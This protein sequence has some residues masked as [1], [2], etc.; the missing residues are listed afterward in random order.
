MAAPHRGY[1]IGERQLRVGMLGHVYYRKVVGNEGIGNAA[2]GERDEQALRLRR[3]PCDR[4]PRVISACR[5]D[6]RQ[7]ALHQCDAKRENQGELSKLGNHYF[8]FGGTTSDCA[9]V[10]AFASLIAS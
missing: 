2:E 5:A 6:Q 9:A 1:A 10:F 7:D 4:H 8:P 3:R